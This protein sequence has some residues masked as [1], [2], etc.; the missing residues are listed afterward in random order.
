MV[1]TNTN[2][3]DTQERITHFH[4]TNTEQEFNIV[5]KKVDSSSQ[6]YQESVSHFQDK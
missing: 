3:T 5:I 1:A 2:N 4:I 6:H